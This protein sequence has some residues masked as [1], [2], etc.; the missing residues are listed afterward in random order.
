M[1][2]GV[3][4]LCRKIATIRPA[5]PAAVAPIAAVCKRFCRYDIFF[6]LAASSTCPSATRSSTSDHAVVTVE[7]QAASPP[8]VRSAFC[9][10][11]FLIDARS[12]GCRSRLYKSAYSA[13]MAMADQL[14]I[15]A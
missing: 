3:T 4:M 12:S 2:A 7:M 1:V 10:A 5:N 15:P 11:N 9:C 13:L 8:Q 14:R 6:A